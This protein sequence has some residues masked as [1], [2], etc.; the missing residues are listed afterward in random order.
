VLHG[1]RTQ[2]LLVLAALVLLMLLSGTF[3]HFVFLK[4]VREGWPLVGQIARLVVRDE[5]SA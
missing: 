3:Y 5:T 1:R 2:L 4:A